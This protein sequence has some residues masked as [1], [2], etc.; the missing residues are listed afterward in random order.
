M[1]Q[2]EEEVEYIIEEEED[3][4][5]SSS[6]GPTPI[7]TSQVDPKISK[8]KEEIYNYNAIMPKHKCQEF[9][10]CVEFNIPTDCLPPLLQTV[11]DIQEDPILLNFELKLFDYNWDQAPQKFELKNPQK[12]TNLIGIKLAKEVLLSEFFKPEYQPRKYYMSSAFLLGCN[13]R[14]VNEKSVKI[15]TSENFSLNKV[16]NALSIC[17][18]DVDAAREFLRKGKLPRLNSSDMKASNSI[19]F[20]FDKCHLLYLVLET[21]E[22]FLELQTHCCI[23]RKPLDSPTIKPISCSNKKCIFSFQSIGAGVPLIDEIKRDLIVT[24]LLLSTFASA[25]DTEYLDPKPDFIQDINLKTIFKDMESINLMAS[26]NSDQELYELVGE[27]KF[28]LIKWIIYT[29]KS[30]FVSLPDKMRLPVYSKRQYLTL[31][32]DKDRDTKFEKLKSKYGSRFLWHGSG[33]TKWYSILRNGL[34]NYSNTKRMTCGAAYGP[35][36]YLASCNSIS[37]SYVQTAPNPY[38]N[39]THFKNQVHLLALCEVANVP[40]LKDHG[41]N[42]FTLQNEDAIVTRVLFVQAQVSDANITTVP[43]VDDIAEYYASLAM[44]K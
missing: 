6:D 43:T 39:S 23:C 8:F 22:I 25:I 15:L 31:V 16:K 26:C 9:D 18:G 35:G 21:V 7:F 29:N 32:A 36:I 11:L 28:N 4:D 2:E 40:E 19:I 37:L 14:K 24:D 10:G 30:H 3:Y 20:S 17:R 34:K 27:P 38:I 41:N 42:I 12:G 1:T 33:A 13:N 5:E 44:S